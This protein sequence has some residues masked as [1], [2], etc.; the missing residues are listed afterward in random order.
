MFS[1]HCLYHYKESIQVYGSVRSL[2]HGIK[3]SWNALALCPKL[4]LHYHFW[5]LFNIL[6][7]PFISRGHLH[8]QHKD[9]CCG[10]KW[11][12][13]HYQKTAW[14]FFTEYI[15]SA[16]QSHTLTTCNFYL[17]SCLKTNARGGRPYQHSVYMCVSMRK[18]VFAT[19]FHETWCEYYDTEDHPSAT[20]SDRQTCEVEATLLLFTLVVKW[21][22]VIDQG[23]NSTFLR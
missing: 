20:V 9:T 15:N 10:T 6:A 16:H 12:I 17:L 1:K 21:H 22:T 23:K 2:V 7:V 3:F 13:Q 5:T 18:H 19:N 8:L 11:P 4:K 14:N